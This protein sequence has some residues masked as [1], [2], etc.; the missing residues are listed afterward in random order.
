MAGTPSARV[1]SYELGAELGRGGMGVV[2]RARHVG[3]GVERALKLLLVADPELEERFRREAQALARVTGAGVVPVHEAGNDRGRFYFVMGLMPGGSLEG[4]LKEKGRFEWREAVTLVTEIARALATCHANGIVHRDMK[5]GNVLFDEEGRPRL[6]DFGCVRDLDARSLTETGVALGTPAYMAPE[7]LDGAKVDA[8]ADVYALGVVLYQL[9]SGAL[10]HQGRSPIEILSK[11]MRE[12]PPGLASFGVPP[13]L[14][15]VVARSLEVDPRKRY[16]NAGELAAAFE[17]LDA[18]A[19]RSVAPVVAIGFV[20]VGVA[21]A[22][23]LLPRRTPLAPTPQAPAPGAV[24]SSSRPPEPSRPS[25][26][27]RI[28]ELAAKKGEPEDVFKRAYAIYEDAIRS[29]P[30]IDP[31]KA[32]REIASR[33]AGPIVEAR[34][35][36]MT[37][38]FEVWTLRAVALA[39]DRV[40]RAG[41]FVFDAVDAATPDQKDEGALA[42]V[43][44]ALADETCNDLR[45]L[46]ATMHMAHVDLRAD[47]PDRDE[48]RRAEELAEVFEERHTDD[49]LDSRRAFAL[50]TRAHGKSLEGK[51]TEALALW[52]QCDRLVLKKT[53]DPRSH[54]RFKF[55]DYAISHAAFLIQADRAE[56]A[57]PV[58]QEIVMRAGADS[59]RAQAALDALA[60]GVTPATRELAVKTLGGR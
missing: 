17:K 54:P 38:G 47:D 1:G 12:R 19:E 16:A 50:L 49:T 56:A 2:Y 26:E 55:P 46:A 33:F 39:A 34:G 22:V 58:L 24:V 8:R 13:A 21:I 53:E 14:D 15:A 41:Q 45:F 23:A 5:P 30:R 60:P 57:K 59:P 43:D 10:P 42:C 52:E 4:R 51:A 40:P 31:P 6:S 44:W 9:L 36:G 25:L 11:K 48:L 29:R 32:L 3:T 27:E 37:P 18:P 7:Q 35:P 20:A 28:R